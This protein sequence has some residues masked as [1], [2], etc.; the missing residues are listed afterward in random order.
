MKIL[1]MGDIPAKKFIC[2]NCRCVFEADKNEFEHVSELEAQQ[3]FHKYKCKCP[4]CGL[5]TYAD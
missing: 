1:K 4:F 3:G 2:Y 5:N